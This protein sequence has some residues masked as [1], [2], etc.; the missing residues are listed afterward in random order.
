[1]LS[2]IYILTSA[3]LI[4]LLVG[5]CGIEKSEQEHIESSEQKREAAEILLPTTFKFHT[6]GMRGSSILQ[7][8]GDALRYKVSEFRKT[9]ITKTVTPSAEQWRAF[10]KKMEEVRIW[11]W[12]S[13][14]VP[15]V[16]VFDGGFW[17]LELQQGGKIV[18]SSGRNAYPDDFR[19]FL[20]AVRELA[21]KDTFW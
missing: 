6:G 9:K 21:G 18:S 1:M 4:I 5:G 11:E 19:K 16:R 17:N 14:Y 8:E 13:R 10:W 12:R 3:A 7:W 20:E 2:K 15:E